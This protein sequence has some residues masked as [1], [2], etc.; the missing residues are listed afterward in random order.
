MM[1]CSHIHT[2]YQ[3]TGGHERDLLIVDNRNINL[4]LLVFEAA[5]SSHAVSP[6]F[7]HTRHCVSVS[8]LLLRSHSLSH[9][10]CL[11]VSLLTVWWRLSWKHCLGSWK[12]VVHAY[13][14]A[15]THTH[16]DYQYLVISFG[17]GDFR[18]SQRS[19][20]HYST[21]NKVYRQNHP[22]F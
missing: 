14:H 4:T 12:R 2:L 11:V 13:T 22:L 9:F 16:T 10:L 8:W 18:R 19:Q 1:T 6:D 15:H 5:T 21:S 17:F 20:Y 7:S 3:W